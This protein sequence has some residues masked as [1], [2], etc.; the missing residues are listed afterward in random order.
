[1]MYRIKKS[2]VAIAASIGLLGGLGIAA[3]AANAAT[4]KAPAGIP[5]KCT[6]SM[7]VSAP[8]GQL[9]QT[10]LHRSGKV[11][12][13][14]TVPKLG[15]A[16][17][18]LVNIG[19]MGGLDYPAWMRATYFAVNKSGVAYF[20]DVSAYE[21]KGK[22]TVTKVNSK[23]KI[24]P[25]WQST[26]LV[27]ATYD[28]IFRLASN[29]KFYSYTSTKTGV[30]KT[31]LVFDNAS[32][33]TSVVHDRTVGKGSAKADVLLATIS[34]G[35]LREY[36]IPRKNPRAAKQYTLRP[37]AAGW[38]GF[39]RITTST[40]GKKGRIISAAL[41]DG[42]VAMYYDANGSDFKGSDIRGGLTALPK[43]PAGYR[44]HSSL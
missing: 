3:P 23:H 2:A 41:A 38:G 35:E 13:K 10:S 28:R 17:T 6:G 18:F 30:S 44:I 11:S 27:T 22:S 21:R 32:G 9:Y 15:F 43:V 24:G 14:K 34:N 29:G 31:Q 19:S 1:M 8:T 4:V 40:C 20:M 16:P 5:L 37:A 25:G 33:F 7:L 36:V 39:T 12:F 26:K 42:R